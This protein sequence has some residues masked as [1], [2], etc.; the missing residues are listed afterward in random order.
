MR[1]PLRDDPAIFENQHTLAQGNNFLAAMGDIKN[2]NAMV[3]VP[4]SQVFDNLRFGRG[5]QPGHG[6]VEQEQTWIG[7]QRA[8]QRHPLTL[9]SRNLRRLPSA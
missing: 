3:M 9:A 5:I 4:G 6:F 8:S 1:R 2:G 7:H